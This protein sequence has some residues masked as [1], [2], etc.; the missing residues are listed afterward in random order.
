MPLRAKEMLSQRLSSLRS[1][2]GLTQEAFAEK[3]GISYKYYQAIEEGRRTD[4]RLSTLTRLAEAHQITISE[5]L[6][7]APLPEAMQ[8]AR[9][10]VRYKSGTKKSKKPS[11]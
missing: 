1:F 8:R 11:G 9:V 4:L 10:S 6:G 7:E 5:M 2:Q 3:A